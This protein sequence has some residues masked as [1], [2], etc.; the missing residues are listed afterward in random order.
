MDLAN[1]V[2][3]RGFFKINQVLCSL[4]QI[5]YTSGMQQNP[6][7]L[8]WL[9]L[10]M[11][12]LDTTTDRIIEIATVVTDNQLNIIAEGP[13][14]AIH[15]LQATLDEMDGWNTKQH[16]K[17]G[18]TARVQQ[19]L[20]T[21]AAAEAQTLAFLEQYVTPKKSP[22]CGNSI[23][24]DRRFL[25]RWMPKLEQYFH[26]RNLDV[27]TVKEL[28]KHWAP[29][30]AKQFKKKSNHLALDDIREAIAELRHYKAHFFSIP[31]EITQALAGGAPSSTS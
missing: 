6:H 24:Q 2:E 31:S 14:L 3:K 12:G 21:E 1:R 28:A 17:S 29:K 20:V 10:E 5:Q 26:Y 25:H 15:Q 23:C 22:M 8:I 4:T 19:S 7:Y 27:S 9:D 11:T 18:L 16:A 30:I 13:M